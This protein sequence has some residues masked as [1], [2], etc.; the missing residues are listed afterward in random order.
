MDRNRRSVEFDAVVKEGGTIVIPASVLQQLNEGGSGKIHVRVSAPDLVADLKSRDVVEAEVEEIS[1][2]Q[3]ESREQV[4]KFLMSE[5][6]LKGSRA[7]A[8]AR[9]RSSR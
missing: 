7:F 4:L 9:K 1:G 8:K 3:M 5:G 6:A 2:V